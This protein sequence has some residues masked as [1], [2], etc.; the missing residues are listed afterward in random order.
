MGLTH[1]LKLSNTAC[2]WGLGS[3]VLSYF[4]P[5]LQGERLALYVVKMKGN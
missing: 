2:K 5:V 3:L 1:L 4:H